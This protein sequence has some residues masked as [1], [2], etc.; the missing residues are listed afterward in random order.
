MTS[1]N[2]TR[3]QTIIVLGVY[4]KIPFNKASNTNPEIMEAA[5]LIGRSP[6]SVK[7]KVGNFGSFDPQLKA[8]GIV[9]LSNASRLD[10]EIWNEYY[11]HWDKLAYDI[12]IM[13][14]KYLNKTI[15]EI[16]DFDLTLPE[17]KDKERIV[18]QRINQSF[19]R[20]A[21]L[22]SY[23]NTCCISHLSCPTLLEACHIADWASDADNRTN[24]SNGLCLNVLFH[25]AY[26]KNLIGITPDYEVIISDRLF[27]NSNNADILKE[28]VK[29]Y[30]HTHIAL[31][32]R[33]LPDR[34]LLDAHYQNF[35]IQ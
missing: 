24:P 2:W 11:N 31:P 35:L 3:E 9:G 8:R 18:K 15:E 14:A 32:D 27:A 10:A 21:V 22:T 30:N 5:K 16:N 7:M 12:E 26:D 6:A 29:Q 20:S 25:K 1:N 17:G 33:F 23:N 13:K 34:D 28:C 4:C 19:F